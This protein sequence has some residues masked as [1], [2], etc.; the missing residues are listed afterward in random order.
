VDLIAALVQDSDESFPV[1]SNRIND[2]LSPFLRNENG[3]VV[4]ECN[5]ICKVANTMF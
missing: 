3:N 2:M 4:S 5:N 1:L